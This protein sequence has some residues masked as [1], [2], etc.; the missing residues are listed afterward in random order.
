[1]INVASFVVALAALVVSLV[2]LRRVDVVGSRVRRN[3]SGSEVNRRDEDLASESSESS[4]K[5]LS[6]GR[7]GVVRYDAFDDVGGRLSFSLAVLNEAGSGIVLTAI[8]GRSETRSYVKQVPV[9]KEPGARQLSP[10]EAQAVALAE[11]FSHG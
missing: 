3:Q 8:H 9:G 2:A 1:M 10:E 11:R 5:D 4:R 7:I 6:L